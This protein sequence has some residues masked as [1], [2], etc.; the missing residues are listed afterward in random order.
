MKRRSVM[1]TLLMA[2]LPWCA[3]APASGQEAGSDGEDRAA[4]LVAVETF[5]TSMTDRDVVAARSVLE[6][7]GRFF[8]VRIGADGSRSVRTFTN[9]EYLDGLA[10]GTVVQRERM[11]DVQIRIHGDIATAWGPYDFHRDGVFSHCGVDAVDLI[12][13]AEGWRITGGVYTVEPEGCAP[14]PLGPPGT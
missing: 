9:Q 4:V 1:A 8:S 12:R 11:W 3:Y 14:S 2:V 6:P 13:T 10:G 7:L 5:F